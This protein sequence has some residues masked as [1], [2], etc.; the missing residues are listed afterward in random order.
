[1][2]KL[3]FLFADFYMKQSMILRFPAICTF[4][5]M[6]LFLNV[7][8]QNVQPPMLIWFKQPATLGDQLPYKNGQT[9]RP[10]DDGKRKGWV[11][12][13]PIGNGRMGAMIFGG[14]EKERIQ[15]N[16]E[17]LWAG[18]PHNEN[19]PNAAAVLPVVR[20]LIFEGK[21]DSAKMIGEENML[22]IPKKVAA[23]QPMGD[24]WIEFPGV[25]KDDVSGYYRE[26]N[27]DSALATVT[28][29]KGSKIFTR[30]AFASHPDNVIAIRYK[31][32]GKS[33][34]S[35]NLTMDREKDALSIIKNNVIILKGKLVIPDSKGI[36]RGMSFETHLLPQ[37]KGGKVTINKNILS[38]ANADEVVF[39]IAQAT[40]YGDKDAEKLC[41][42]AIFAASKLTYDQLKRRH[43][44]DYK[45]LY[46][47]VKLNMNNISSAEVK[48]MP[49]DERVETAR[50]DTTGDDYLSALQYQYSRY[51]MIACSRPGD[52]PANLQGLWNQH[53]NPAWESDYHTNINLQMN[54][55]FVEAANLAECHEPLVDFID[56]LAS[57]GR[58][59][60]KIHYGARGWVAHHASDL[61]G[62]TAPVAGVHGV[63][64]VGG[65]WT[66]RHSYEHY[67]YNGNKKFLREKAYPQIRGAAEFF[68]DFLMEVPQGLPFAGKLV[69]NPSHSPENAFE[70]TDGVQSQFTYGATMDIQIIMDLFDNCLEAISILQKEDINFD[71]D[72]KKKLK[73]AKD[74]LVPIRINAS[75]RIQEWIEDYKELE[76][77]HRHISHLYSLY[78]DNTISG[79]KTPELAKAALK[80]LEVRLKGNPDQPKTKF[81]TFDSYLDGKKGTGWGRAWISLFYSRLGLGEE[82]YNHHRYLQSQFT[83]PNLL[84][85]AHGTYQID[86]V[87]GNAAA[88]GEMLI[89]SQEG[90]V[91]LLPALPSKWKNG[92]VNGLRSVGGFE[93]DMSWQ[94]SKI[95][96]SKIKSKN[97]GVCTVKVDGKIKKIT[98]GT[99]NIKYTVKAGIVSFDTKKD[100]Q[101]ELFFLN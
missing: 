23:Y 65:A 47:R 85:V 100:G 15:L 66:A 29:N 77:G 30:E 56:T 4:F 97:G 73:D 21:E 57:H 8:G 9:T 64:P 72:F 46:G 94:N 28:F 78:P 35:L 6:S 69:T 31:A 10:F 60:A 1:M 61:F 68:L 63:W 14:I 34:I 49:T 91:H 20:R 67:L 44:M 98:S 76:V 26:L 13:L 11:E 42:E 70:R 80:T 89:Q 54:Y 32:S 5:C 81:G 2:N 99:K 71:Q 95:T 37:V 87:F 24:I 12:S 38:I 88:I 18:Y 96:T 41:R 62:Y 83:L 52:W 22:G 25:V 59:T 16:E 40:S 53:L 39:L 50:K 45:K 74:R 3:K 51:L 93:I 36:N 58:E 55:W 90:F 27:I 7:K 75:G 17:T 19:N 43:I 101:Y 48:K 79:T 82:A 84:G 92:F 33:S 86:N